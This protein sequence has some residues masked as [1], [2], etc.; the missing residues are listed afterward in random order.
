MGRNLEEESISLERLTLTPLAS[1]Y[2][3]LFS[4]NTGKSKR[5][6][7][8]Q[9]FTPPEV[10]HYMASKIELTSDEISILDPCAG[11]GTLIAA[12]CDKI[13]SVQIYSLRITVH[14]YEVDPCLT[15]YLYRTLEFCKAALEQK[16]HKFEYIIIGKNFIRENSHYLDN[17]FNNN[18][19]VRFGIVSELYV[20]TSYNLNGFNNFI[21]ILLQPLL[22]FFADSKH[23]S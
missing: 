14:A 17:N 12:L 23:G 20:C 4:E 19:S 7:L 1:N 5:K 8:G 2:A 9:F 18:N 21:C 22:E 15:P 11:T 10:A 6:P 13:I 3:N 16:E